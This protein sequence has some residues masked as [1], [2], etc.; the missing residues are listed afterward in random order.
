MKNIITIVLS[1]LLFFAPT[2]S[3]VALQPTP[4]A[5]SQKDFEC[6][7]KNIY[8][9]SRNQ[10]KK[11]QYAVAYVTMN[12]VKD[13][14]F[15]DSVCDVVYAKKRVSNKMVCQ[16]SWVCEKGRKVTDWKAYKKA[17]SIAHHVLMRYNVNNDPTK[18]SLFFHTKEVSPK[19]SRVFK[20]VTTIG[21]HVFYKPNRSDLSG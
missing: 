1:S 3:I 15:N 7:S 12:R 2:T 19:W 6:L 21:D 10:P 11:G 9:E 8:F 17:Q 13:H 20:K 16:F 5:Y 18:G 4:P 14:R